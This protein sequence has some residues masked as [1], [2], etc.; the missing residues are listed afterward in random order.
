MK[1]ER[2]VR[3]G[4]H[5]PVDAFTGHLARD[6]VSVMNPRF[7]RESRWSQKPHTAKPERHV[8]W[9]HL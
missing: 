6:A 8:V 3:P 2:T 9:R 5:A 4:K 1:K 7:N